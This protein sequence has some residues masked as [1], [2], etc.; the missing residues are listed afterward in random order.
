MVCLSTYS[1][2]TN[3]LLTVY[4]ENP[5]DMTEHLQQRPAI[6]GHT[7]LTASRPWTVTLLLGATGLAVLITLFFDTAAKAVNVWS[8]SSAYNYSF[9][10]IPV[11]VWLIWERH[12]ELARMSPRPAPLFLLLMIPFAAAWL[13]SDIAD[14]Y[15]GRQ[16][17]LMGMIQVF[18]LSLLG[19]R[20]YKFLLFPLSYLWLLVPT[21]EFLLPWLQ[22][23]SA[24]MTTR[25]IE[26]SG[27]PVYQEGVII[28]V[29][30]G[31]YRV[32][33]ECA[34]LNFF[35]SSF[36]LSL[37]YAQQVY[38]SWR[39]RII[40]IAVALIVAIIANWIRIYAIIMLGDVLE[41]PQEFLLDHGPYGWAFFA[42][43]M[44][45]SMGIGYLFRDPLPAPAH[46][47]SPPRS[48]TAW[49]LAIVTTAA[50]LI[51]AAPRL[52]AAA[53]NNRSLPAAIAFELPGKLG[54]WQRVDSPSDWR[55]RIPAADIRRQGRYRRGD[56]TVDIVVAAFIRQRPGYE[57]A[58]NRNR[59]ADNLI[60]VRNN[61]GKR[62]ADIA[63]RPV[64][65]AFERLRSGNR[66]RLVWTV[67]WIG[68]ELT[69]S[70]L[71]AKLLRIG[72][73]LPGGDAR[74][75]IIMLAT[76]MT[77]EARANAR[78]ADTA[79]SLGALIDALNRLGSAPAS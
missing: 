6:G 43:V 66:Q 30:S 51:A 56:E 50:L 48:G 44:L 27:M 31:L 62:M 2:F 64:R 70:P 14:I 65:I 38:R 24:D 73:Q 58:S 13:A 53:I 18:L 68:G 76:D 39:K 29:P 15:E 63:G 34:G 75:A 32:A 67:F 47:V 61:G 54:P 74:A 28:Q 33:P 55:P 1:S 41:N 16:F 22:Q 26:L 60:W 46:A 40:C 77:D 7:S 9:L 42:A 19:W 3:D 4:S 72:S 45:I 35:L 57:V 23:L 52:Y 59:P 71:K 5:E 79:S 49:R 11:S 8:T 25:M 37:V 10:I 12:R 17:A 20:I 78:L 69:A 36:A 21:G